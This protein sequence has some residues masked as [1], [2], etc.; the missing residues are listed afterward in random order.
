MN[1]SLTDEFKFEF[2]NMILFLSFLFLLAV[3]G[4]NVMMNVIVENSF[5]GY[6]IGPQ[7]PVFVSHLQLADDTLLV[8]VKNWAN[9]RPLKDV[10]L[11]LEDISGLKVNFH[12]SMLFG[13]NVNESWSH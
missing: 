7:I 6:G 12:K 4:L 11:L 5:T 9:V 3:E 2:N 8:G 13:V 1:E 10:L